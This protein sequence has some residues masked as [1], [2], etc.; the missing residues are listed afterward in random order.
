MFFLLFS[1]RELTIHALYMLSPV[2]LSSVC[3]SHTVVTFSNISTA[4]GILAILWHPR[5]MLR[6]SSQGN[7]PS[8]GGS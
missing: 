8:G 4:F 3:L 7:P 1:K 5:K 2:P 6:K